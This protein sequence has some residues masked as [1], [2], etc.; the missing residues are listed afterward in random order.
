MKPYTLILEAA[1]KAVNERHLA[2]GSPARNFKRIADL[3]AAYL[4]HE[5]SMTD[6]AN[7]MIL[8]K[9]AR[10]QET[11]AHT[12]SLVDIAGYAQCT[13]ELSG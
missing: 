12:D 7:L 2:Y 6:V 8:V 13:A 4:G 3:W 10:L 1:E 11:P 9:I 5:V